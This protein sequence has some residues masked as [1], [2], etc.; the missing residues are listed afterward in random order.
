VKTSSSCGWHA[1][2]LLLLLLLALL[3]LPLLLL[4]LLLL[5]LFLLCVFL[6]AG[7][8]GKLQVPVAVCKEHWLYV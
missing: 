8:L 4:P 6:P 2:E 3:L 1:T 5:L 7:R